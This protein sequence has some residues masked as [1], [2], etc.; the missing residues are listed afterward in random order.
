MDEPRL[1][2]SH[3]AADRDR[4]EQLL[5][6][7]QNLPIEVAFAE[8]E[9]EADL[10]R[11]DLEGQLANSDLFLPVLTEAGAADP[12]VN[13][14]IGYASA[15]E[16]PV[17]VLTND[18]SHLRGYLSDAHA[19]TYD[20]ADLESTVFHLLSS[21]RAELEP[22]GSLS[23]PNWFLAF[24]C[25]SEGCD[26]HVELDV[27]EPQAALWKLYEHD[28]LLSTACPDCGVRYDFNPATLG[29][30]QRAAPRQ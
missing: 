19:T 27:D 26:A 10:R 20:P 13:Q 22:L 6:P 30:V 17:A 8:D 1:F 12:L 18:D 16:I 7:V 9:L 21:I 15:T 14:E 11:R 28:E 2:V 5:R 29:F 24:G 23:T 25:T 3:A 4:L